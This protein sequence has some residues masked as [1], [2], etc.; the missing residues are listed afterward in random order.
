MFIERTH[1]YAKPGKRDTV[2]AIRR[3]ACAVRVSIGISAGSVSVKENPQG[4]GPDVAWE[5]AFL[6]EADHDRD[7]QARADSTEFAAVREEMRSAIDRFERVFFT[8]V[9]VDA[10]ADWAK[11]VDLRGVPIVPHDQRRVARDDCS[12]Q[13]RDCGDDLHCKS[14]HGISRRSGCGS[15]SGRES[16]AC[17]GP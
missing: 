8:R 14:E 15:W 16:H 7:L 17:H 5:C 4:D 3:K 1:Y 12:R 10:N 9:A 2:L 6:T 13:T 11:S